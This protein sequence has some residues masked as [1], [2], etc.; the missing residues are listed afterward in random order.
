[1]VG[2]KEVWAGDGDSTLKVIDITTFKITDIV[3]VTDPTNPNVKMRVDEMA[4]DARDHIL[5][6]ANNANVPPFVTMVN[7]D[8]T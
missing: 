4:W 2:G 6:A 7:T 8:T 1:M 5:A 3:T